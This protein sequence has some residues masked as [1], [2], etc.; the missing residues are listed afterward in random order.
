LVYHVPNGGSR[1]IIEAK[2]L[3][4]LGVMA[5]VAD[6]VV[7]WSFGKT[8]YLEV[9]PPN[10]KLSKNQKIF[11]SRCEELGLPYRRIDSVDQV[12]TIFKEW[13]IT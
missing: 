6:L 11:K 7:H 12:C 13:G 4:R 5:G 2:N 1:N 3:K 10:G 8:G 9:K